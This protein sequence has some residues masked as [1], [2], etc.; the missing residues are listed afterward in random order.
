MLLGKVQCYKDTWEKR[1]EVLVPL[2]DSV[3][4]CGNTKVN[5]KKDTKRKVHRES[6]H[7]QA[8]KKMKQYF[9]FVVAFPF[10]ILN[11]TLRYILIQM[12]IK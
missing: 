9:T 8:L 6:V 5:K 10:P 7:Q 3:G 2:T 11:C 4:E 12:T 1:S